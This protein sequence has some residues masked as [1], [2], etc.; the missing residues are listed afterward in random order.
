MEPEK[1]PPSPKEKRTDQIDVHVVEQ[2]GT[3][4]V[5]RLKPTYPIS[6]L[7]NAFCKRKQ[8]SI[9]TYRFLHNGNRLGSNS[10]NIK[11]SH[12]TIQQLGIQDGDV[13]DVMA[14]Q[15]GGDAFARNS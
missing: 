8:C 3:E 13:I 4:I 2:S 5:F 14:S 10:E 7:I 9:D 11:G 6:K 1:K 15:T 12:S